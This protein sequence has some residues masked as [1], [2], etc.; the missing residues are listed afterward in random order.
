MA[1]EEHEREDLLREATALVERAE[2]RV[3][4]FAEP[5][6]IG[7]RRDGCGSIYLGADPAWHF[8]ARDELRRAYIDGRLLKAEQG[9]LVSLE[10]RRAEGQVQL[11]RHELDDARQ[12]RLVARLREEIEKLSDALAT[13]HFELVGQVPEGGQAVDRIKAWLS[14]LPASLPIAK[15]PNAR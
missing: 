14:A 1:R 11:V 10:R 13:G 7:F 12:G 5:V 15:S 3:T 8:N 9:R 2:L 6:V 4:G